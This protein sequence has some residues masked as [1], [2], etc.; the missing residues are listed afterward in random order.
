M[1]GFF[2]IGGRPSSAMSR[3]QTTM[4]G[5]KIVPMPL[6][7]RCCTRNSPIRITTVIGTMNG[8]NTWVATL[9]PSTA[10]STEIAG[11]IMPSP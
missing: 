10:L 11:V 4:I 1:P 7:P 9:K 8:S 3:N 5:P 2:T 6:V